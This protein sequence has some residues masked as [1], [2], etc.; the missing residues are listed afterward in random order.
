MF[1]S[2]TGRAR[3]LAALLPAVA[4]V[5]GAAETPAG[6]SAIGAFGGEAATRMPAAEAA[7]GETAA[8]T[9]S[10]P[11]KAGD[12]TSGNENKAPATLYFG[13]Y[14]PS[15]HLSNLA[16]RDYLDR[17]TAASD[18]RIVWKFFAGGLMGKAGDI[19][20]TV[21]DG[22]VDAGIIVDAYTPWA[23]PV[24]MMLSH[25]SLLGVDAMVMSAAVNEMQL[26]DCPA[27]RADFDEHGI[28]PLAFYSTAPYRLLCNE[29]IE[30]L[31]EL[32]GKKIRGTGPTA[33]SIRALGGIPVN[34]PTNEM[35]EA[36][37]RGQVDCVAGAVAWLTAYSLVD[38]TRY[39]LDLP[40]GTYHGVCVFNLNQRTLGALSADTRRHLVEELPVLVRDLVVAYDEEE[41]EAAKVAA[42]KGVVFLEPDAGLREALERQRRAEIRRAIAYGDARDIAGAE[43]LVQRFAAI[44]EK[45]SGAV[46][47]AN[48]DPGEFESMI[49]A[50]VFD[51][52]PRLGEPAGQVGGSPAPDPR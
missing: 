18:G 4:F 47:A 14:L 28:T 7:G 1:S 51:E 15:T 26:L 22:V 42:G 38:V 25:V 3:V 45:W 6:T 52:L 49:R 27:C 24:S 33:V 30:T 35:F 13:S 31:D 11:P 8:K 44:V 34:I 36:L 20:T 21:E 16:V 2:S 17:V 10:K 48:R 32:R 41:R 29:R 39:V 50:R 23:L 40:L 12:D 43:T 5:A 37:Q 19:L 9:G 46:A